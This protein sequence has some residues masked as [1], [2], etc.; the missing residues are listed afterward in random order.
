MIALL[1]IAHS[2]HLTI[3]ISIKWVAF[4]LTFLSI[5]EPELDL[6]LF[7]EVGRLMKFEI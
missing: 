4:Q 6:M 5:L 7:L 2:L 3:F 1:P